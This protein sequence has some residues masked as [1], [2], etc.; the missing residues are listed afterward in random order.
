MAR[1]VAN[2]RLF[3]GVYP[4]EEHAR[5]MLD[6]MGKLDLPEHRAT[7]IEQLH[8]TVQFV[9]DV[10]VKQL[11]AVIESV[12]RSASGIGAFSLTP[13]RLI[14][15]PKKGAARLVAMETDAPAKLLELQRRLAHRLANSPRARAGDRF[16]PHFTLCRF[17]TPTKGVRLSEA[18]SLPSF[19]ID[20][21]RLMKSRLTNEG[22]IHEEIVGV[23]LG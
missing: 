13:E 6:A 15:L 21:V 12:E 3:V 11:D 23:E 7:A 18:V 14:T 4:P 22:A 2:L 1:P 8:M 16:L 10:P 5:T 19:E 20:A 17:K 9:G